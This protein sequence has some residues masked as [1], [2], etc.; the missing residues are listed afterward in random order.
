MDIKNAMQSAKTESNTGMTTSNF[1]FP[2]NF[3]FNAKNN[4]AVKYVVQGAKIKCN[5]GEKATKLHLPKNHGF[6]ANEKPVSN[7]HDCIA[8]RN[9]IPFGDCQIVGKCNPFLA[10]KW[11][12]VKEDTRIKGRPAL[13]CCSTLGC[14]VGGVITIVEDGQQ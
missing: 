8:N 11:E 9:I 5:K 3:D 10:P 12:N 1:T 6:Y 7:D 13:L 2:K 14:A 4:S